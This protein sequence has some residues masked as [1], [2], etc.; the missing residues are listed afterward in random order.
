MTFGVSVVLFAMAGFLSK[1]RQPYLA[2]KT[3]AGY[4][5][6]VDT[7]C[8]LLIKYLGD[9]RDGLARKF[10]DQRKRGGLG[11]LQLSSRFFRAESGEQISDTIVGKI[12]PRVESKLTGYL[13]K[14][15][16]LTAMNPDF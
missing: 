6:H 12:P 2:E 8:D 14:T 15:A 9:L 16:L 5:T 13:W 11:S 7:W 3:C 10:S 1:N 4:I